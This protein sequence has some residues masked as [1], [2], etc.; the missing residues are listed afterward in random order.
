MQHSIFKA[1][2]RWRWR[3]ILVGLCLAAFAQSAGAVLTI[4]IT[5]GLENALPIAIV[6]FSWS[7]PGALP[8]D[9]SGIIKADLVSSG[10]FDALPVKDFLSMPHADKDVV[11]KDWRLIKAEALVIG[12]VRA[13]PPGRYQVQFRLYDVFTQ[14]QLA[15]YRY[16]VSAGQLRTV[17]HQISDII[18]Q[19]LTG[20][21]GAFDTRIAYI[22]RS[23]G[24]RHPVF[25]LQVADS[26]GYDPRTIL[27]SPQ[28][29]L[30]PRW[31][32]DGT[33]LAY[34]SFEHGHAVVYI[35]NVDTGQRWKVA[36]FRG[37]NSAPAWSPH[38]RRLALSLSMSGHPEI[39]VMNLSDGALKQ[40]THDSAINTEPSWSP[41]GRYIAFTS[42][43][44][45]S[46]QIFRMTADGEDVT[47]LTFQGNYNAAPSYSPN[48]RM[49]T[50]I[51]EQQGG[52]H[53]AILHLRDSDLQILTNT[54]LD[55]SPTFAPNG[56]MVLYATIVHGRGVLATVSVDGNV[57]QLIKTNE[58]DV[59]EP[60]WSPFEHQLQA[61]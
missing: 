33:R 14:K 22:T 10:R 3:A 41:D 39:Y 54:S 31:S 38:G 50:L 25:R 52:F 17:A 47:R 32:P 35:Q 2:G 5:K 26:D 20:V 34:V 44:S 24:V 48:G 46:P 18:Y 30:T 57:R 11:F 49:I 1:G 58:G 16:V 40:L 27:R 59:R 23:G 9:V 51:T 60:A 56:Q 55:E 37:I 19:K 42:D 15:G 6:P 45:G 13:L 36:D 61:N 28:P 29:L 12:S 21:P 7:G 43:R 53:A 8:Q 4:E